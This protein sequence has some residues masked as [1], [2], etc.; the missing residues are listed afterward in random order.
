MTFLL[1][2]LLLTAA[3]PTARLV[4]ERAAD[5]DRCARPFAEASLRSLVAARLTGRDPFVVD[6]PREARVKFVKA[7][8]RYVATI[9]MT[10][11]DGR[12]GER[13][14]NDADCDQLV[15][16]VALALALAVDPRALDAP[17]KPAAVAPRV[18]RGREEEAARARGE[19]EATKANDVIPVTPFWSWRLGGGVALELGA[20]PAV[21]LG[22]T[23]RLELGARRWRAVLEAGLGFAGP[24]PVADTSVGVARWSLRGDACWEP[25]LRACL[26]LT[27]ARSRASADEGLAEAVSATRDAVLLGASLG[28]PLGRHAR[29]ELGVGL[30]LTPHA[31]FI[32]G[33]TVAWRA[34]PLVPSVRLIVL[35]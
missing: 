35:P 6:A 11:P 24:A 23:L 34:W 32:V 17:P 29:F 8:A 21:A 18:M 19:L 30:P 4:V 5:T 33:E 27:W 25:G 15:R 14:L 7:G 22:P 12:Q 1:W 3:P 9:V 2:A 13:R 28:T 26:G 20:T 31:T 10:E 16:A